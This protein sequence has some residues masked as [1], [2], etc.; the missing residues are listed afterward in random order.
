MI[1]GRVNSQSAS[2]TFSDTTRI[3][4]TLPLRS[5][6]HLKKAIPSPVPNSTAALVMWIGTTFRK[7]SK[8]VLPMHSS[9]SP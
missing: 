7:A 5:V 9:I 3:A 2:T 4:V 1:A 8:E 6:I